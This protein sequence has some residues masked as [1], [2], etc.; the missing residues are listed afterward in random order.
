MATSQRRAQRPQHLG[1]PGVNRESHA[2]A[3]DIPIERPT[4]FELVVNLKVAKELGITVPQSILVR[5]DQV[6]Q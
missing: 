3:A 4:R 1:A 5:A 2:R 6:V